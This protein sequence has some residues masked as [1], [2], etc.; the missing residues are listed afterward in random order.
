MSTLGKQILL[1]VGVSTLFLTGCKNQQ[2]RY[3]NRMEGTWN[4]A[5]EIIE[6]IQTDGTT[7]LESDERNVGFFTFT[8]PPDGVVFTNYSLVLNNSS[9]SINSEPFKCDEERKRVFFYYFYC[10]DLFGCDLVATIEE[11]GRNRQVW[12]FIRPTGEEVNH[13]KV[14][15]EL[16]KE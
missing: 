14:T 10:L 15:W 8:S 6:I 7:T 13:R 3:P 4:I 1:W 12:S 2:E 11:D 5:R 16:E 9:F